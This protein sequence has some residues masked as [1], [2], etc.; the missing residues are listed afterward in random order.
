MLTDFS[1]VL[2]RCTSLTVRQTDR[3]TDGRTD[4]ILIA[5][6]RLRSATRLKHLPLDD[7]QTLLAV[8]DAVYDLL[9]NYL[10]VGTPQ[11]L[12][13]FLNPG[14][15]KTDPS[16]YRPLALTSC[17]WK[18]MERMINNRLVWYLEKS[19]LVTPVQCGF[20]K[21]RSITDH[22]ISWNHLFMKHLYSNSTLLRF[23]LT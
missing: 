8:L 19:K 22:L 23:S 13:H 21:Q 4:R 11:P 5:K 3:R 20:R 18:V 1:S 10:L 7:Q 6:P 15:D 14:R 9:V 16:S 17:L 12:L 2:S